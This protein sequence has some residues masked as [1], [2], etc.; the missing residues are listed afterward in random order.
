MGLV[1]A[2]SGGAGVFAV[3][4]MLAYGMPPINVL[5]LNK[6]SDL[7]VLLG[8][9]RN[10]IKHGEINWRLVAIATLPLSLGALIG[11]QFSVSVPSDFLKGFIIFAVLVGIVILL[12][13]IK[14]KEHKK[15]HYAVG[16]P[17]L[18]A[19]GFW[20]G[21]VGMAGAT[22]A[23]LVLVL[24]FRRS[25]LGAR[26]VEIVSVIPG[27]FIAVAI[28]GLHS[29]LDLTLAACIFFSSALGAFAGSKLAIKK[30]S[31]F[32]RYSMV[33]ISILML[34]KVLYDLLLA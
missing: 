10:Y 26:S 23:V 5:A 2:I 32:I 8:A 18:I 20:S 6:I 25:F 30:G 21:A 17:A 28:L 29:T 33:G 15:P 11:A 34:M 13:P 19:V 3:P 9:A 14:P 16:I 1:T 27:T 12:H 4:A 31:R 22:F 7:G 24:F